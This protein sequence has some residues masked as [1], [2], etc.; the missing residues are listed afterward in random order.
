[1][2]AVIACVVCARPLDSLLTSGLQ[3]GVLVLAIVAVVVIGG[4]VRGA[5]RL[6]REDADALSG[7]G[8]SGDAGGAPPVRGHS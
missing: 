3:A 6:L 8:A 1:M 4:L 2:S 5:L 7:A